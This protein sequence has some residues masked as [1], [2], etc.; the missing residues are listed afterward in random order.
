MH[1]SIV[2]E[3]V[4]ASIVDQQCNVNRVADLLGVST[5]WL[6]V[7]F[8]EHYA[9]APRQFIESV[10][11]KRAI[12]FLASGMIL[13]DVCTEVGYSCTK[14]FAHACRRRLGKTPAGLR[15]ELSTVVDKELFLRSV[16]TQLFTEKALFFV[17]K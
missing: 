17:Q 13:S 8:L 4:Y 15:R 1:P 6:Q 2:T 10:R 11:L 12:V 5:R 14:T 9:M 16:E 7:F 3:V